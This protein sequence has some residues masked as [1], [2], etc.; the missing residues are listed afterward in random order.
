MHRR[1]TASHKT[2]LKEVGA[3]L[4]RTRGI[5]M[6]GPLGFDNAYALVMRRDQAERLNIRS[7]ADLAPYAGRLSIAGDY[8]FFAR[9]EWKAL[10]NAYGLNFRE[11][12]EMQSTFMYRAVA[13]GAIDVISGYSSDGQI[14]QYDLVVLDDPKQSLPPYDAILLLS[15]RRAEDTKFRRALEPLI[16]RISTQRMRQ[17]NLSVSRVADQRTPE[18]AAEELWRDIAAK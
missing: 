16:G 18:Q 10:K 3:W 4:K 12:R 1:E 9:P 5:T 6:L 8:E 15:P 7:I 13:D 2:V 14:A 17:A 11:T